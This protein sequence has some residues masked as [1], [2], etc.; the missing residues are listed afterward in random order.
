MSEKVSK[1]A[2]VFDSEEQHV[3][4]L[5][6]KALLQAASS[7]GQ[8]DNVVDELESFVGEVFEKSPSLET[9]L[10]N[11]KMSADEKIGILDRVFSSSMNSTLLKFLKV[12]CRRQR[13]QFVRAIARSAAD[14]RDELAGRMQ[15]DV[16]T[17]TGLSDASSAAL[18]AKLSG[19]FKKEVRLNPSVDPSILGGLVVRVGDTVYDGSLDGQLKLLRKETK[20]KAEATVRSKASQLAN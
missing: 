3:G 13:M 10:S 4:Q 7:D 18:A 15:V 16:I 12:L 17:S 9:I 2:T 19:I 8:V 20:V 1:I 5:Y 11:P 6:A 14:Q